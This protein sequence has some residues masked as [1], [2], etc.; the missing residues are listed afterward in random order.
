M[1]DEEIWEILKKKILEITI[2]EPDERK[3]LPEASLQ[4]I[5]LRDGQKN[6]HDIHNMINLINVVDEMEGQFFIRIDLEELFELFILQDLFNL[7]KR[8]IASD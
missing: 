3:L 7:I 1:T 2:P 4:E 8:K 6:S 5:H